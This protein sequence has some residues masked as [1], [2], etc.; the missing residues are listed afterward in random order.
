MTAPDAFALGGRQD[1]A[2]PALSTL[3]RERQAILALWRQA[4]SGGYPEDEAAVI[5]SQQRMVER[6]INLAPPASL[7][8]VA[9]K[10]RTVIETVEAGFDLADD[11]MD[12]LRQCLA[13]AEAGA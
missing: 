7:A 8:D 13:F 2:P 3:A 1:D 11:D 10:L 4:P 9:I 5:S 12:A 6:K